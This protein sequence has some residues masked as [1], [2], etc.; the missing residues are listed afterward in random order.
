LRGENHE[1][2]TAGKAVKPHKKERDMSDTSPSEERPKDAIPQDAGLEGKD[3]QTGDIPL[4]E[5][6]AKE[7]PN[8]EKLALI[9]LFAATRWDTI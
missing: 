4:E 5:K 1:R 2:H 9:A 3:P 6:P 7:T 8:E